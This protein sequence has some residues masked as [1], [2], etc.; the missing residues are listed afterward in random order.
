[1]WK[2]ALFVACLAGLIIA[3]NGMAEHRA[4]N[5]LVLRL[6]ADQEKVMSDL[7]ALLLEPEPGGTRDVKQTRS[8]MIAAKLLFIVPQHGGEA[9]IDYLFR[10]REYLSGRC[11]A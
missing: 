2:A 1:M 3:V 5:N 6:C 7:Q 11:E 8:S 4:E 10:L 9:D